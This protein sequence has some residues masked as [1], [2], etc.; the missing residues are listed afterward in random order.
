MNN[1]SG[2]VI[3]R[4]LA[5]PSRYLLTFLLDFLVVYTGMPEIGKTMNMSPVTQKWMQNAYLLCFGGFLLLSARLGD[6]FGRRRILQI[7]VVLLR[8]RSW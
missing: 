5:R 7:R 4:Q 3:L 1:G 2:T 6:A 8:S